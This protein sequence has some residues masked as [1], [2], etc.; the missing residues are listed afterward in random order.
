MIRCWMPNA[1]MVLDKSIFWCTIRLE[2]V[3]S[4]NLYNKRTNKIYFLMNHSL[5]WCISADWRF[6]FQ[7][8]VKTAL[9]GMNK[10][11]SFYITNWLEKHF[12]DQFGWKCLLLYIINTIIL[13]W[14]CFHTVL[15]YSQH[16]QQSKNESS[17]IV[18]EFFETVVENGQTL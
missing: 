12:N 16:V 18:S 5:W 4:V 8:Q 10:K 6:D 17:G 9:S 13:I 15:N 7:L 2:I 11:K 1:K 3:L 14:I